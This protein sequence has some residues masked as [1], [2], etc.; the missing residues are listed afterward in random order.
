M[1]I[2]DRVGGLRDRAGRAWRTAEQRH[3]ALSHVV[4][5]YRHYQDNRGDHLAA[6]ITY[7]SFLALFPVILLGVSVTGFVLASHQ[8]LQNDLFDAIRRN[9]PGGFGDTLKQ[10]IDGAIRNRGTVGA[11]GLVGL[12]LTGLGWIANL[13]AAIDTVWGLPPVKRP[14]V[15][16]KLA[17]AVVLVGLG[18]GIVVSLALTAGGTAAGGALLRAAGLAGVTGAGTA[19]ALLGILLGIVGST[20]VFGWLMIR[21]PDVEVPRPVAIRATLLAAIG[22]EVLKIVGT[23]YI[24]RVVR[25]PAAAT[26]G[27]VIGIVVFIDLVSRYLLFCI[28]WASTADPDAPDAP[29]AMPGADGAAVGGAVGTAPLGA[30]PSGRV[31]VGRPLV[32]T[33]LVV[34]LGLLTTGAAFGAAALAALLPR[35]QRRRPAPRR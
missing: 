34:A 6:A 4:R 9:V 28:A 16:A 35:M 14:F 13:R 29:A 17:D 21:L 24:A 30:G 20:I 5:A 31:P 2:G 25:S 7:F 15:K 10:T 1:S 32:V 33:P 26:L 11:V 3:P 23:Y 18:L 12:A 19:T 8:G 22:F 27:P